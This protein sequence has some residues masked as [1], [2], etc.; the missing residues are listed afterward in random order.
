MIVG[1]DETS[2]PVARTTSRSCTTFWA[3]LLQLLLEP[4]SDSVT[5][6]RAPP[7]PGVGDCR[8]EMNEMDEKYS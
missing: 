7:G 5:T 1:I 6:E 2:L 3:R 8:N 4:K